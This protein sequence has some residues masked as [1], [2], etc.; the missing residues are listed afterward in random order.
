MAKNKNTRVSILQGGTLSMPAY[1]YW[2][3]GEVLSAEG[4]EDASQI[5]RLPVYSVLIDH[6]EG[7][8]L[9]DSGF[10]LDVANEIMPYDDPQQTEEETIPGQLALLGLK[11]ED[12][13]HV[14][15]THLHYDHCGYNKHLPQAIMMVHEKEFENAL[16]P[17]IFQDDYCDLNWAPQLLRDRPNEQNIRKRPHKPAPPIKK[18]PDFLPRFELLK[19]DVEVAEGI[20]LIET[21]GHCA[22]HYTCLI[23]LENRPAMVFSGDAAYTQRNLDELLVTGIH[24]DPVKSVESLKRL[25]ILRASGAEIFFPHDISTWDTYKKAPYWYE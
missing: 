1:R 14:I 8:F 13:T 17:Q 15:N 12:I 25:Q 10:D 23:E 3:N 24:L 21:P 18:E 2:W 19:G 5:I 20:W 16:N 4:V 6:A 9:L 22:G 7:L 11:P